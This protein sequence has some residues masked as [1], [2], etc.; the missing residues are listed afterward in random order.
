MN[1]WIK[2]TSNNCFAG[3][4]RL[5]KL[6]LSLSFKFDYQRQSLTIVTFDSEHAVNITYMIIV[7][8]LLKSLLWGKG[9]D[10]FVPIWF[11]VTIL[12]ID[13]NFL[14]SKMLN[15]YKLRYIRGVNKF[16][17]FLDKI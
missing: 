5:W 9:I 12:L 3:K 1:A 4:R 15:F 17:P 7:E 6:M 16:A 11:I 13:F 14:M 2:Q 10:D 8:N